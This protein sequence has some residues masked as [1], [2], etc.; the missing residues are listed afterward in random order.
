MGGLLTGAT[1]AMGSPLIILICGL[2]FVIETASVILQ[3]SVFKLSGRKKRLFRMAPIHHHFEQCG[4]GEVKIVSVF[5]V[6]TV[7]FCVVAW[8]AV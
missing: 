3:V 8:F 7:L 1:F 2:M 5:S 6:L 4:W